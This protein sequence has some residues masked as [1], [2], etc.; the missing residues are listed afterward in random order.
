MI[1]ILPPQLV[2]IRLIA[3]STAYTTAIHFIFTGII[4]NSKICISGYMTA[5]ARNM[6]RLI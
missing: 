3:I 1:A 2:K 4:K 5:K 6:V